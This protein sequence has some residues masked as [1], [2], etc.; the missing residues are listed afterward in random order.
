MAVPKK[1]IKAKKNA[2]RQIGKEKG[3]KAAQKSL[4]LAKFMLSGKT[5]SLYT[6]YMLMKNKSLKKKFKDLFT[7]QLW[8]LIWYLKLILKKI[9]LVL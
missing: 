6:V 3:Y 7:K 1:R 2:R 9:L 5:T 8:S 4:S